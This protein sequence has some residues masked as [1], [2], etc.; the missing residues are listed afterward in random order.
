MQMVKWKL[1]V[2][3]VI[4]LSLYVLIVLFYIDS[5]FKYFAFSFPT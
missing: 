4:I 1:K 3:F 5:L 2:N